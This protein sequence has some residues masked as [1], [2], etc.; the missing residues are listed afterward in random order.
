MNIYLDGLYYSEVAMYRTIMYKYIFIPPKGQ[1]EV[2]MRKISIL[3]LSLIL[4]QV[5]TG[6]N[7]KNVILPAE[8]NSKKIQEEEAGAITGRE[9]RVSMKEDSSS[10][11]KVETRDEYQVNENFEDGPEAHVNPENIGEV[12]IDEYEKKIKV[13]DSLGLITSVEDLFWL[14]PQQLVVIGHVNP[15]LEC[16]LIYDLDRD[17][18]ILEK[19]GRDFI[20]KE[21]DIATLIYIVPEPHF[22]RKGT[23][24]M[25]KN[26]EDEMLYQAPKGKTI[27][28]L[29]WEQDN[30]ISF[31]LIEGD[32]IITESI[33]IKE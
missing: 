21:N 10:F 29:I 11:A 22:T 1:M 26:Y 28:N 13:S 9:E 19:Y 14:D 20:W 4:L 3:I 27:A 2:I 8:N 24:P 7:E 25:I 5:M 33:E 18:I 32:E 17:K 6:C 16:L 15:S 30:H 31:D 12:I 23:F